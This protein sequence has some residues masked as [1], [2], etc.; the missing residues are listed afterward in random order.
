MVIRSVTGIPVRAL[1]GEQIGEVTVDADES[2]F[3][4]AS[5][6]EDR[7]QSE[8]EGTVIRNLRIEDHVEIAHRVYV[9]H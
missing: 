4:Y 2:G 9:A 5:A 7:L 8:K 1:A 6:S 3:T